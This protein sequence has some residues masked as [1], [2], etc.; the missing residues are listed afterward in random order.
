MF[1]IESS[2]YSGIAS[3]SGLPLLRHYQAKQ[4]VA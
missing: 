1:I 3:Y 4:A 2:H